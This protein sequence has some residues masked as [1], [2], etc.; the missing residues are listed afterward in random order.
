MVVIRSKKEATE[1]KKK[2]KLCS[3]S[4]QLQKFTG[5]PELAR[6][7]VVIVLIRVFIFIFVYILILM[8]LI[9]RLSNNFGATSGSMICKI[10]P[11]E[12]TYVVMDHFVNSLMLIQLTCSK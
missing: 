9:S 5:V 4:P 8:H 6:T 7:E 11:I 10:L 12:G 1:A 2:R 3:L